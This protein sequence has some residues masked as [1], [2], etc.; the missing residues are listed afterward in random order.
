MLCFPAAFRTYF[1]ILSENERRH[2]VPPHGGGLEQEEED[3]KV[4]VDD[5]R[6]AFSL[7]G[8]LSVPGDGQVRA[9]GRPQG[10]STQAQ[11]DRG[12]HEGVPE[13]ETVTSLY[14]GSAGWMKD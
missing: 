11:D 7:R 12:G 10:G 14:S 13:C 5:V 4:L 6:A 3:A 9:L 2:E 8:G 1:I